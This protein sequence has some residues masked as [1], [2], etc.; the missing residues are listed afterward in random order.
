MEGRDVTVNVL[1]SALSRESEVDGQLVVDQTGLNG[2]Y[3]FIL[4]WTPD[5]GA[6]AQD[7]GPSLFAAVQE[8]QLKLTPTKAPVK[9]VVIDHIEKPSVDG[10]A[11]PAASMVPVAMA[12]E[13][14]ARPTY[15]VATIKLN[16]SGCCTSTKG[17]SDQTIF[18]NQRL[19]NLV[20]LAYGVQPY[21]VEA[22]WMDN[23]HFDIT[24]KYPPGTKFKDR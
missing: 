2:K 12:Q 3:N 24:A 4:S 20:V 9:V 18:T 14:P 1:A 7:G 10:A 11:V 6:K 16:T 5:T 17:S 19:K 22:A 21:Q 15:E 23:V 8:E 13:K